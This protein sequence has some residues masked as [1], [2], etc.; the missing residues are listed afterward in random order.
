MRLSGGTTPGTPGFEEGRWIT[1][2]DVN[3][4]HLLDVFTTIGG[5]AESIWDACAKFM[6]QLYWH[7]P[8][9]VTLGPKIE[10]LPDNHPSKP[11]C[12]WDLSRL[13]H[14]VGN[15]V[16]CERLLRLALKLW[17]ERGNGFKV[18][19]ELAKLSN[20]NREMGLYEEGI[21]QAAEASQIFERIGDEVQQ[22]ESLI[23]LAWSLCGDR[24]LDAAKEAA[25]HA[26][27]L[28][29]EN[30]EEFRV[31]RAHRALGDIYRFK[32]KTKKAIHH[33]EIARGIATS[34]NMVEELFWVDDALAEMFSENGKFEEAQTHVEH[35]KPHAVNNPYFLARVT[36]LQ[37]RVWYRQGMLGDAKS[38]ALCALDAFE[39]LGAADD[40]ERVR[41]LLHDIEAR[42]PG[43]PRRF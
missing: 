31:C 38:E 21:R 43:R 29:P 5:S 27:D 17:R 15:F 2:E 40:A 26:I 13:L 20:A 34:L 39:R 12:L 3:I 7:K 8:R 28:L 23:P 25:S 1:T 33:F 35:A 22:A 19:V 41:Q 6:A 16:E 24:Q 10:A 11:Q 9:L 32:D 36:H 18:G 30:G 37:A 42:R 14:L 4:E